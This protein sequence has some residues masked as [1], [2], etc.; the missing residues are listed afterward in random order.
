[1]AA[2]N[3]KSRTKVDKTIAI[4]TIDPFPSENSSPY[5]TAANLD[6]SN[7]IRSARLNIDDEIASNLLI[8]LKYIN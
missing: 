2:S 6:E 5:D 7:Y 8:S 1:M 4:E 3:A